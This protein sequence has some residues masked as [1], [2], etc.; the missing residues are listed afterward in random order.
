MGKTLLTEDPAMR[1]HGF[2]SRIAAAASAIALA[3][4]V[5]GTSAVSAQDRPAD[6]TV[7]P[8]VPTDFQPPRTAWGDPDISNSYQV[9]YLNNAR[10]LFQR[11]AE[12][13]NRFWQT[14]EEHARRVAAAE[15]SDGNFTQANEN[16]IG[17]G[18]TPGRAGW[19][20]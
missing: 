2:A 5:L 13:G 17:A 15:R 16:G 20:S 12:Y 6:L 11:P 1:H 18:G 9:E 3:A 14:D 10:V 4:S 8:P 19:A 7:L